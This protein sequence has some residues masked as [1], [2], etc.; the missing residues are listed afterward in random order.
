MHKTLN[1]ETK[2]LTGSGLVVL[3]ACTIF[4]SAFL[5]FQVQPLISKFILPWFGGSPA[6]WTTAMLFFQCVLFGGYLYSH[7][8]STY[9]GLQWQTKLHIGL[10]LVASVMAIFVIPMDSLKPTGEEN[11]TLKILLLL[12]TCV[13]LPYFML[14]TTGPLIQAWFSR[15]YPGASP[16]RLFALSNFG[17]L[18]ALASFPFLFEPNLELPQ[19]GKFWMYGFWI[20]AGMCIYTAIRILGMHLKQQKETAATTT[21][22]IVEAPLL[23]QKLAWLFLP[24]VASMVFIATSNE[25]TH[26]V[27]PT[28]F[29]WIAPLGL[30][31]ITFIICFDHERWYVRGLFAT[32]C[33]LS[34]VLLVSYDNIQRWVER[35][36]ELDIT[37]SYAQNLVLYFTTM[38]LMC[39]VCHGEF[40]K[41]RPKNHR[42]LTEYYLFLSAGGALGGLF[43]SFVATNFFD[44]Y[45]EWPLG[46]I[47]CFALAGV[48][49]AVTW[50][51]RFA[52]KI[53]TGLACAAAITGVIYLG[54]MLN[55]YHVS[56]PEPGYESLPLFKA[57]NFYGTVSVRENRFTKELPAEENNGIAR[58]PR[59]NSRSFRSGSILHG[60]Q[61]ID[62][63]RR[64]Q[65]I[66]YYHKDSGSGKTIQYVLKKNADRPIKFAV[67]GLGAGSLAAFARGPEGERAA[68][69][70]VTYE[71]NPL[72]EQIARKYFWYLPDYEERTGKK[73][74]VRLGDARLTMEREEP[75]NYDVIFLDAF[76]GD[77]V[78]AHLLTREAFEI[79]KKHLRK[80]ADGKITGMIVLNIT[81]SY[82]N[83]YPVVKNA[84]EQVMQMKYTSVYRERDPKEYAQRTHYFIMSNDEGYLKEQPMVKRKKYIFVKNAAGE[85]EKVATGEEYDYDWQNIPLWTDH[86]S[87]LFKILLKD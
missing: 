52:N 64:K 72:V 71:I 69:E 5:L 13:G 15:A 49:L 38:F 61:L 29:L 82:L 11:P 6:V 80:D 84:A 32:L 7:I 42:Y 20:F 75:Q 76:S 78:P 12:G 58:G 1:V 39:M 73:C 48:V 16:Y 57:R 81:N 62:P 56:P 23:W 53:A 22:E 51:R 65:P 44:D 43:I 2:S 17:S 9:L 26:N 25:V 54:W 34:I 3:L 74:E 19:M 67:V 77:S 10:L 8:T 63:E 37:L 66:A 47:I 4:V 68:D 46:L 83:L 85:E 35:N 28:P 30:Y 33:A 27:A 31:L 87:N 55:P 86:Y 18:L 70:C 14:S 79:Y 59:D 24:A 60:Q 50:Q 40:V 45:H 41:L 36:F 21:E